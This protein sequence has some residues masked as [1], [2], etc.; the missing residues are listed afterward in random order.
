MT[1]S[2]PYRVAVATSGTRRRDR[3]PVEFLTG[4]LVV[5]TGVVAALVLL[6]VVGRLVLRS[7][8]PA[9][10]AYAPVPDTRLYAEI[11][12]LRG[13]A[14]VQVSYDDRPVPAVYSGTVTVGPGRRLCPVL[15]QVYAILRQGHPGA[16]IDV[17]VVKQGA[18][19]QRSLRMEQ[20]DEVVAAD[21]GSRY[22]AQP[23]TGEPMDDRLCSGSAT[24]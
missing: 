3:E 14:G 21:P 11:G 7:Q 10:A 18:R 9:E 8:D 20:V 23:G 24:S 15:D 6:A 16:T 12:A 19:H 5:V 22:G 17:T 1:R 4:R 13:I 2:W